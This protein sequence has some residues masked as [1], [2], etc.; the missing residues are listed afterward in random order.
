MVDTIPNDDVYYRDFRNADY[1]SINNALEEIDWDQILNV[2]DLEECVQQFYASLNRIIDRWIPLKKKKKASSHP[3]WF[4][5]TVIRLKNKM[6]ALHKRKKCSNSAEF[7][8]LYDRVRRQ[9]KQQVRHSF[10]IYKEKTQLEISENPQRFYDHVREFRKQSDAFPANMS[11]GDRKGNTPSEIADLFRIFFESVYSK[12]S[13]NTLINFDVNSRHTG[14]IRN[15][16]ERIP[17]IELN[18]EQI[19][20]KI[21]L[22]PDNLVAGPDN[23]PNLFVKRCSHSLLYPMTSLLSRTLESSKTPI[24]WKSSYVRPIFKSGSRNSVNNYRG[25]AVQC[26]IPKL[27]DSII[28]SHINS[29]LS[30]ILSHHQH[31][32]MPGKSTVTNLAEFLNEAMRNMKSST[33]VDAIYLDIMK[34]FDAVDIDLL[35]HK[36]ELMGLNQQLLN[37]LRDYLAERKQIVKLNHSCM[38]RPI[39]VSSGVGQGYPIGAELFKLFIADAPFYFQHASIYLFADDAKLLLPIDSIEDCERLQSEIDIAATY[40]GINRLNPNASKTKII[41]FKRKQQSIQFNY[42]VNG[43]EIQRVNVITDLGVILDEKLTFKHHI[44]HV[45]SR[46]KSVLSWIK[47]FA[48]YFDDPYVIKKLYITYVL[49]VVEYASQIW[50]PQFQNQIARIESIQKQF[51]LFALRSLKWRHRFLLP[52]YKHRLLLLQM[53]TLHDRRIIAQISFIFQLITGG[54]K[55]ESLHDKINFRVHQRT[56]RSQELLIIDFNDTDPYNIMRQKFNEYSNLIDLGKSNLILK[57][58]LKELFKSQI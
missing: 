57:N 19:Q 9:Y 23:L 41:T 21:N 8:I 5:C 49:P 52:S 16:C 33:Q 35:C 46:A 25:V 2:T 53:N 39:N 54:I 37:W 17:A 18:A 31:G 10:R 42:A 15:I 36:L 44:D 56:L 48:F 7:N 27:L 12:P 22:L 50:S 28:A 32:F 26:T 11:F 51:L 3:K 29:H 13:S 30:E 24:L 6:N 45:V 14:R 34:A 20:R 40:F 1:N 58:L 55:S 38:S 47:R 43:T 4:D